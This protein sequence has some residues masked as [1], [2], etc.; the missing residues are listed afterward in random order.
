MN[1]ENLYVFSEILIQK[2]KFKKIYQAIQI[3]TIHLL[4]CY[5]NTFCKDI[6]YKIT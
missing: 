1:L 3:V 6:A 4:K 2:S 5:L